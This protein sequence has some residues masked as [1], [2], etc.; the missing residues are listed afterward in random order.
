MVL[1]EALF[2]DVLVCTYE[3]ER[4]MARAFSLTVWLGLAGLL[5]LIWPVACGDPDFCNNNNDCTDGKICLHQKCSQRPSNWDNEPTG[6]EPAPDATV[7]PE[8]RPEPQPEPPVPDAAPDVTPDQSGP[9]SLPGK[10]KEGETC[11][12]RRLGYDY[13]RCEPGL[14][15]A[16]FA[17]TSPSSGAPQPYGICLKACTSAGDTSC[18][19]GTTC[20][21]TLDTKTRQGTGIFV[22]GKTGKIGDP[23]VNTIACDTGLSCVKYGTTGTTWFCQKDCTTDAN[24]C[25]QDEKCVARDDDDTQKVCKRVAK[26]GELCGLSVTCED[27]AL[28]WEGNRFGAFRQVCRKKCTN[29]ADCAA[30]ESCYR[31]SRNNQ[32][33]G[34][35]CLK[36]AAD[37]E[38]C[39]NGTSCETGAQCLDLATNYASCF[40]TCNNASDCSSSQTCQA[41]SSNNPTKICKSYAGAGDSPVNLAVCPPGTRNVPL[42][43]FNGV[44]MCF[45]LCNGSG[46]TTSCGKLS[47]GAL[48]GVMWHPTK[49]P[50]TVGQYGVFGVSNNDGVDW[51]R[52]PVPTSLELY[53]I[54]GT[55]DGKTLL[56]V[57]QGGLILRSEDSGT[58]WSP[59]SNPATSGLRA[60]AFAA[61]GSV[62]IAVGD[63]GT[64]IRSEDGG[65]TWAF[66]AL[67]P[68][69]SSIL[70]N[71]AIGRDRGTGTNAQIAMIVGEKGV[72]LRS[73]DAG[74]T[75]SPISGVTETMYAVAI[76][77]DKAATG[78]SVVVAGDKG[79][80]WTSTDEGKTLTKATSGVTVALRGAA[81][82]G[83]TVGV[84]GAG[85]TFIVDDGTG[86]KKLDTKATLNLNSVAATGTKWV[87]VGPLGTSIASTDGG[88]SFKTTSVSALRC[89][90]L[91]GA[92]GISGICLYN[93]QPLSQGGDCPTTSR[94]CQGVNLG[95]GTVNICFPGSSGPGTA[96]PGDTCTT[97][98]GAAASL[99]C[100]EESDCRFSGNGFYCMKRC[101]PNGS[102]SCD[103]GT[104]CVRV[105]SLGSTAYC[106]TTVDP[107]Q[108]CDLGKAIFCKEGSTCEFNERTTK[109]TCSAVPVAKKYEAC[110]NPRRPCE[111]GS[112]C[113][114]LGSTPYRFYC[115]DSCNPQSP[116]CP[117]GFDCL[118]TSATSGICVE[119][120][121]TPNHQCK[122]KHVRCLRLNN[123]RDYCI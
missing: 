90:G 77:R 81:F 19:S 119:R 58:S 93:C 83:T 97:Y 59:V 80:V 123:G 25:A 114:G 108:E 30:D 14:A 27:T 73:E 67:L 112:I 50:L 49:G 99:R 22:C 21:E 13:D 37:G 1:D 54:A 110:N 87:A 63:K 121:V 45:P 46:D 98:A 52:L 86:W 6:A 24:A 74:K 116:Q 71:V 70:Y 92:S 34:S 51:S 72:V 96:K 78:T 7:Q 26:I 69:V 94:S 79:E 75:F 89:V 84:V 117:T 10:R 28:C 2:K 91:S 118:Q 100:A 122:V 31:V 38:V 65:K 23:C 32:S 120:C 35:V 106:G 11:D 113:T 104:S 62:A 55:D 17:Q 42:S 12:P 56:I 115:A 82:S 85:G 15:C 43:T 9:G 61:D 68:T 4:D 53:S 18:P 8:P 3:T 40:D 60:V 39:N 5:L 57:G 88:A 41:I 107:G 111:A 105:T 20:A 47:P 64:I 102:P 16:E 48:Y 103:N 109:S 33:L 76:Q 66:V 95:G 101:T 44:P 36:K 29:A